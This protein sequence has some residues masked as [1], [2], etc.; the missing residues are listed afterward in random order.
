MRYL[1]LHG[2]PR[3]GPLQAVTGPNSLQLPLDPYYLNPSEMLTVFEAQRAAEQACIHR[4]LPALGLGAFGRVVFIPT[5][6]E[7]LAYLAPSQAAQYGYHD[8]QVMALAAQDH[9]PLHGAALT[10]A[11]KVDIGAVH[12]FN[13]LPV[14]NGGCDV[15]GVADV[16]RGITPSLIPTGYGNPATADGVANLIDDAVIL[17]DSRVKTVDAKWSMCMTRHGDHYARPAIAVNNPIWNRRNGI[18]Y[19]NPITAA[20][21]K[22]A[23]ADVACRAEVN[24]YAVY[25]AVAA[26]YQ[27]EWMASPQ[28]MAM[29]QAEQ[30]AD[31]MMLTRAEGILGG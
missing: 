9:I 22:T 24:L 23:E 30:K 11:D 5:T 4:Y 15:V 16:T 8:P 1:G 18:S 7:P 20:E 12:T 27:R 21:I 6:T 17:N 28:N 29:A 10:D 31:Q 25:W 13:G 14:P 2:E 19:R 3:I 26:A